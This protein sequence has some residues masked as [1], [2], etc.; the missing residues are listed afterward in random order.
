MAKTEQEGPIEW[1]GE[2]GVTHRLCLITRLN[3][4]EWNEGWFHGG[5]AGA[6]T[7]TVALQAN[8]QLRASVLSAIP[9]IVVLDEA[10]FHASIKRDLDAFSAQAERTEKAESEL[11]RQLTELQGL[12]AA[13]QGSGHSPKN[14]REAA[15]AIGQMHDAESE[16]AAERAAAVA[17]A[18]MV[19]AFHSLKR[20]WYDNNIGQ[21]EFLE[22]CEDFDWDEPPALPCPLYEDPSQ[23]PS[24]PAE[25]QQQGER[26]THDEARSAV[27]EMAE[28]SGWM[29]VG[30][31]LSRYIDQQEAASSA[32]NY[33]S[34][35]ARELDESASALRH[36]L[37]SAVSERD[38]LRRELEEAEARLQDAG[39][40][41]SMLE[42]VLGEQL[43]MRDLLGSDDLLELTEK[44][45]KKQNAKLQ[46]AE[47]ELVH[48]R[49]AA[50]LLR[51]SCADGDLAFRLR[52]EQWASR[53]QKRAA[54]TEE[55]ASECTCTAQVYTSRDHAGSCP[56]GAT[57]EE[58]AAPAAAESRPAQL[59]RC[60]FEEACPGHADPMDRPCEWEGEQESPA[61][62]ELPGGKGPDYVTLAKL[63][64]A[65][66]KLAM[67]RDADTAPRHIAWQNLANELEAKCE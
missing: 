32:L 65:L 30:R 48:T 61:K 55:Q 46:A 62:P 9:G 29:A 50:E 10:D 23:R 24:P 47:A 17:A 6:V 64:A 15:Q 12:Y 13:F 60:D 27:T 28:A 8:P 66:R 31:K 45:L 3:D 37:K 18:A 19:K 20:A 51:D 35:R 54:T 40:W 39:N 56:A 41:A 22:F 49:E 63:A 57:T 2:G 33:W 44:L 42:A 53:D 36:H 21:A 38:E 58:Q 16:L 67:C 59:I 11:A 52:L 26:V 4:G 14:S 1:T 34:T 25:P 7:L 5:H 43:G